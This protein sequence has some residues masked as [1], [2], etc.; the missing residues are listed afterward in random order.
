MARSSLT[1]TQGGFLRRD[2]EAP[3]QSRK[4]L[5]VHGFTAPRL[6]NLHSAI[7]GGSA[8]GE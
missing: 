5:E 2:V 8:Y 7:G 6:T 1:P 3:F 4:P